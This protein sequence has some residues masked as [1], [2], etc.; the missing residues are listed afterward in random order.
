QQSQRGRFAVRRAK[1]YTLLSAR[2]LNSAKKPVKR[3]QQVVQGTAAQ[4]ARIWITESGHALYG[5]EPGISNTFLSTLW[6]LDQLALYA[7][8][9]VDVVFRQ[10]LVGSDYGLLDEKTL[11]PRPDYY[12][13]F[14]WKKLIRS[15]VY[16]P[17][18]VNSSKL[19][20]WAFGGDQRIWLIVINLNRHAPAH[21]DAG[22]PMRE[23]IVF[24]A[25]KDSPELL[26]VNGEPALPRMV[27]DWDHPE[28]QRWWGLLCPGDTSDSDLFQ[29]ITLPPLSCAFLSLVP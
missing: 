16:E 24:S 19:R 18:R 2:I 26:L 29:D 22:Q 28:V 25:P 10:S 12:A 3:V 20:A 11:R 6:W 9:G 14:L 5:G 4:N 17:P 7:V 15:P 21:I 1:P 23:K 27:W 8:E 13:S